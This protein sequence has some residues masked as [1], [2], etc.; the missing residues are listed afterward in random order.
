MVNGMDR[1]IDRAQ[2]EEKRMAEIFFAKERHRRA[3]TMQTLGK[4]ESRRT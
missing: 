2:K 1:A 3:V 4:T